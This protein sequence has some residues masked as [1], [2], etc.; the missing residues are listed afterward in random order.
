MNKD[1]VNQIEALIF[2]SGLEY[3]KDDLYQSLKKEEKY[4]DISKKNIDEAINIL[5]EKYNEKEGVMLYEF[6]DYV[7]LGTNAKY[8]EI[9][10]N[11]L[12]IRREREL[13][14]TLLETLAII[15]YNQPITRSEIEDLRDGKSCDYSVSVLLSQNLIKAVGKKDKLGYPTLYGTTDEF[16]R[17]FELK[18]LDEMP[19]FDYIE[20]KVLQ[21]YDRNLQSDELYRQYNFDFKQESLE[22]QEEQL[23]QKQEDTNK[24]KEEIE[25]ANQRLQEIDEIIKRADID[26]FLAQEESERAQRENTG[27]TEFY[28]LD[29]DEEYEF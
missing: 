29:P 7:Q 10:S 12:Q 1:L 11:I 23:R 14:K 5:K 19:K 28:K 4:Q 16:L 22:T 15:C 18:S 8:G 13:T 9:V 17:K 3:K 27:E 25:L 2:A 6:G 24:A 21:M 20:Q 26:K